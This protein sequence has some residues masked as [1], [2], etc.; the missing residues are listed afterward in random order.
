MAEALSSLYNDEKF[1]EVFFWVVMSLAY[2]RMT[3][4]GVVVAVM[5]IAINDGDSTVDQQEEGRSYE[6]VLL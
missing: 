4:M 6:T 2:M 1:D 5:M 3:K